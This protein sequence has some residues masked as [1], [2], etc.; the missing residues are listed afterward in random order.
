MKK[1]FIIILSVLIM[2]IGSIGLYFMN[3]NDLKQ[4]MV[5]EETVVIQ[6]GNVGK[7]PFATIES[8]INQYLDDNDINK[9]KIAIYIH[10]FET[11]EEY[12]LNPNKDF[13]AASTYKLPLAM[14]YYEM[15]ANNEIS[16]NSMITSTSI[17]Y[18]PGGATY[19]LAVGGQEDIATLLH[20]SVR[21]SDNT[22]SRMLFNHLGGWIDY[23]KKIE[24]YSQHDLNDSFYLRG[25]VQTVQ[26]LS[27]CL[28]YLYEHQDIY[29]TLIKDMEKAQPKNYLNLKV[30]N[31]AIQKYGLYDWALNSAGIVFQDSPYSI[32]VLTQL[33]SYG[34]TVMGDINQICYE[35]FNAERK[36]DISISIIQ[37]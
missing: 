8:L 14:Y 7:K 13:I 34:E 20:R 17:D 31:L 36:W 9:N 6:Q 19:N 33:G 2:I 29:Q 15:A 37:K 26:Y 32:V 21:D 1:K 23:K 27:D 10:N 3:Q 25:N 4:A 5:Y 22:A 35:Y 28:E 30:N 16:L 11:N 12:I 18:E 24:K